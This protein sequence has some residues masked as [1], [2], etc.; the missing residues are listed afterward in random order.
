MH[1]ISQG[2]ALL[3][4][5]PVPS[6]LAW[7]APSSLIPGPGPVPVPVHARCDERARGVIFAGADEYDMRAPRAKR[8]SFLSFQRNKSRPCESATFPGRRSA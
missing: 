5:L 4:V 7:G 1:M 6:G 3:A 8:S 2:S